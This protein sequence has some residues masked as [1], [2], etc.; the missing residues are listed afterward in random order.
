[1]S[2]QTA[3]LIS[4]TK[5]QAVSGKHSLVI[6]IFSAFL[7][8][9]PTFANAGCSQWDIPNNEIVIKQDNPAVTITVLVSSQGTTFTGNAVYPGHGGTVSGF[10]KGDRLNLTIDWGNAKGL[11]TAVVSPIPKQDRHGT[12]VDGRVNDL[13]HTKNW[14]NWTSPTISLCLHPTL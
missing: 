5:K 14:A 9:Q 12:F 2:F 11:Y 10:L 6:S 13:E 7:L 4:L 3:K 1:M 8:L